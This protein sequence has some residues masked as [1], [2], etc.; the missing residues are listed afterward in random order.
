MRYKIGD[1]VK[2]RKDLIESK[3]YGS[4]MFVYD[5]LEYRGMIVTIREV[6][7]NNSYY[8]KEYDFYWTDEMFEKP[9]NKIQ[10]MKKKLG[11]LK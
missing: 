11:L 8:I 6:H 7:N 10:E 3:E 4:K 2:I 9:N 5:M 1:R